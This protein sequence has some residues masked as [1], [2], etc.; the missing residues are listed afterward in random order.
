MK[1]VTVYTLEG[2][3]Q[4]KKDTYNFFIQQTGAFL[5]EGEMHFYIEVKGN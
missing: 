1:V 5:Q 3:K 2:E 4:K